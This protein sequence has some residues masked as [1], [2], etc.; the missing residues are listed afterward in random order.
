LI[1]SF[2][3]RGYRRVLRRVIVTAQ[4]AGTA[5]MLPFV[6]PVQ[7]PNQLLAYQESLGFSLPEAQVGDKWPIP[8]DLGGRL[9]WE[10][11]VAEVARVYTTLPE[12]DRNECVIIG[13]WYGIAGA[14]DFFGKEYGL[15]P[16]T[17]YHNNY[18]LWGPGDTSWGVAIAVGVSKVRLEAMFGEVVEAG[19]TSCEYWPTGRNYPVYICREPKRPIPEVWAEWKLFI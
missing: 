7:S 2:A 18:Y 19:R 14:V 13:G 1:E 10:T 12:E 3:E 4:V 11:F 17:S 6:L 8:S 16:A 15:P 9:C 5:F